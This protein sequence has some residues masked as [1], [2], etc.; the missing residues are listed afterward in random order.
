MS[1]RS[2]A[3]RLLEV[4]GGQLGG[5]ARQRRADAILEAKAWPRGSSRRDQ[6]FTQVSP[7]MGNYHVSLGKP[8][9][10]SEPDWGG[11]PNPNDMT[12]TVFL[13][14]RQLDYTPSFTGIFREFQHMGV[15]FDENGRASE[16]ALDILAC[17]LFRSAFMLDHVELSEGS[18]R[19]RYSPP[20]TVLQLL[21]DELPCIEERC[22]PTRVFLHLVDALAWNEDVKYSERENSGPNVGRPN[23]L[24]TSV[25][26]IG[27][28]LDRFSI[29]DI[30]GQMTVA[31][32]V[33]PTT[34]K[35]ALLAFPMLTGR[36]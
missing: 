36:H 10:E 8:G 14:S 5:L 9:K 16:L 3:L 28:V 34:Q 33:S 21:E 18:G 11:T 12:P 20:E 17:L 26:V 31:R 1:E 35:A 6:R 24:L 2:E 22:L 25:R 15:S 27:V 13:D 4:P 7:K 23:N 29:A 19:W 32:G 30:L